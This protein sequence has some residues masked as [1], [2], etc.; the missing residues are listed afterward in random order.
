VIDLLIKPGGGVMFNN[1]LLAA[2]DLEHSMSAARVAGETARVMKSSNLCVAVA[3][4]P[5]PDFLGELD[6]ERMTADRQTKAE[7]VAKSLVQEVGA[8]PGDIQIEVMEGPVVKAIQ[9][10]APVHGSDLILMGS[11][12]RGILGQNATWHHGQ[13]VVDHA[14]CP[15]MIVG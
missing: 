5:V 10:I 14:P 13:K 15:V 1:I 9:K 3:Y 4:H 8:I 7:A 11:G 6:F 12:H 2:E